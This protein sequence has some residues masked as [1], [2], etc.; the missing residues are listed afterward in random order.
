MPRLVGAGHVGDIKQLYIAEEGKILV[1]LNASITMTNAL[2]LLLPCFY[3]FNIEYLA[4]SKNVF[5]FLEA[6][7]MQQTKEAKKRVGINKFFQELE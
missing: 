6:A 4:S 2:A 3:V 1:K 7:M 5:L